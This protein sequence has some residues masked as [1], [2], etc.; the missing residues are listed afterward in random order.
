[1]LKQ[2]AGTETKNNPNKNLKPILTDPRIII[3]KVH[4][5]NWITTRTP[6]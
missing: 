3:S 1:M 5:M 2:E 4:R 6:I